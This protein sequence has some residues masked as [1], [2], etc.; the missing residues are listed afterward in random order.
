VTWKSG[1]NVLKKP[2][3][4]ESVA[5]RQDR[6]PTP[7]C[8]S[9]LGAWA[10]RECSGI[11]PMAIALS[12]VRGI[13]LLAAGVIALVSVAARAAAQTP[14]IGSQ[15]PPVIPAPSVRSPSGQLLEVPRASQGGNFGNLLQIPQLT[16]PEMP[17]V[18]APIRWPIIPSGF[19]GC[20]RGDPGGF[21][22][23]ATD[24]GDYDIGTPGRI[25]FCY[26]NHG[27]DFQSAK[28]DISR[29]AMARVII[30]QLGLGYITF[31]AR[32]IK[33]VV[34]LVTADTLRSRTYVDVVGTEH[35][36]YIIPIHFHEH[37][38][39]DEISRFVDAK[40][41]RMNARF[42]LSAGGQNMWGTWHANFHRVAAT[43]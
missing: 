42:L 41:L 40:T 11:V 16:K 12:L 38:L 27:I 24:P 26:H 4:I 10:R 32:G 7:I 34:L 15:Q 43:P 37:M 39:E 9:M 6:Q 3:H 2:L 25:F 28:I 31:N 5:G 30:S 29:H 18:P 23:V 19:V 33:T 20:W 22:E 1:G 17:P 36:L 21:D 8:G 13:S 35:L 14:P